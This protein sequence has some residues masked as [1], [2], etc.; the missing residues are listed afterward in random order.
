M[1]CTRTGISPELKHATDHLSVQQSYMGCGL[2]PPQIGKGS[3]CCPPV[4]PKGLPSRIDW[5]HNYSLTGNTK[6]YFLCFWH[7]AFVI[8]DGKVSQC[9]LPLPADVF[10]HGRAHAE[11]EQGMDGVVNGVHNEGDSCRQVEAKVDTCMRQAK[12]LMGGT[13]KRELQA[14]QVGV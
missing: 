9:P 13:M 6:I 12:S 4:C 2:Q 5:A 1:Y 11:I 10:A 14:G 8:A 3:W 7:L